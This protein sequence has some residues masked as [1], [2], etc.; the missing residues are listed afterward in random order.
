MRQ[1]DWQNP[2]VLSHGRLPAHTSFIPY[3]DAPAAR[4]DERAFS[5]YYRCLNGR[6]KFCY[7]AHPGAVPE[8][9]EQF[10]YPSA[11]E[12]DDIDVPGCWQM[13]GWGRNQYTN[14]NYPFPLNPP[15]VPDDT[16][17]GVYRR[18]FMVPQ[19]WDGRRI[20]LGFDGVDSCYEVFV[21]GQAVG[22]SKVPHMP[23]EF[24]ITAMVQPG[25]RNVVAVR[26]YQWSDGS[27][28]ED[29]D[30][31]RMS[32][33]FR[34]VYMMGLPNVHIRDIRCNAQLACDGR[35]GV[36]QLEVDVLNASKY[37]CE[38]GLTIGAHLYDDGVDATPIDAAMIDQV[39]ADA[40]FQ[41]TYSCELHVADVAP[42]SAEHPRLYT[43][44]ISLDGPS[45]ERFV[46][47][48]RVGF[49]TVAICGQ[50]F[51][52]NGAPIKIKGVNRHDDHPDLGHT[53]S[54]DAMRNDLALMKQHNINA[55]RTSHYPNDARFLDLCDEYGLYV[56]DETDLESHGT[57]TSD[58]Y[59]N[60]SMMPNM[61]SYREAFVD[62]AERMVCRDRNHA[63]I[64]MWSLGN[65]SGYGPSH[66]AMA[67][68]IRELDVTRPIHYESAFDAAVV[69]VVSV[70]YHSVERLI[71]EGASTVDQRPFFLCEYAHAMGNSP[72]SLGDYWDAIYASPR[73]M[74]GCVWEWADHGIRM[75][76]ERGEWFAYGGDFGEYPHDGSF[77]LD[78]LV[79]PDR[80]P[81]NG[82]IE[83]KKVIQPAAFAA[84]DLATGKLRIT[85][86]LAF[87]NLN[88]YDAYW[89][90]ER[91]GA[92]MQEGVLAPIDI[93]PGCE[94]IVTVPYAMPA[95]G[96]AFVTV[97]LRLRNSA[98][99]ASRGHLLAWEQF[100]LP[101]AAPRVT[102][103]RK[104]ALPAL[105]IS[106]GGGALMLE[107]E[108]VSAAFCTRRGL[109]YDLTA[110]GAS[111]IQE[112]PRVNFWRAPTNNDRYYSAEW[113]KAG[114][115]VADSRL[116]DLRTERLAA[117]AVR[118]GIEQVLAPVSR[119]PILR[120]LLTY[121][122]YG[123]GDI[124]V[125]ASFEPLRETL[126]DLPR[127]GM[128][129]VMPG[130]YD[131]AE[132]FGRG[133]HDNYP[134]RKQSAAMGLYG[135][136]VADM[137]YPHI[138][139]QASGAREDTRWAVITDTM[140][141]GLMVAGDPAFSFTASRYTDRA[142]TAA[143]HRFDL[144]Q[145]DATI[146]SIDLAQ[147]GIGSNSCGPR[148]MDKYLLT[149]AQPRSYAFWLK[150]YQRQTSAPAAFSRVL[151]E[152]L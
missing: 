147:G 99:W 25:S 39:S 29:Q 65:E 87:T 149:L 57:I 20:T 142:L 111:L 104:D 58:S 92:L 126:P 21:N 110:S 90:I 73:L 106:E 37:D 117:G 125:S 48:K 23:A 7:A 11:A 129:L 66:D 55:V 130:R 12:W 150:P 96:E 84:D 18:T 3:A 140:G 24:D 151:P 15:F 85:N 49:R 123:T 135:S 26:V 108:A 67:A 120:A 80:V 127:L 44:I 86:R 148:P 52:V 51:T 115:D 121:T 9:F 47:G 8:G 31:W 14:I 141:L 45:G 30:M 89:R 4:Q 62:R 88:A 132:W 69:D 75:K 114:Y 97:E 95:F 122:V 10:D 138:Q 42:W 76:D 107:G 43:L 33:I 68:R 113:L 91:D 34:D 27:Y 82:L 83:Y 70:M 35:D 46:I 145:S 133:P 19:A 41:K 17:M 124:R 40:G 61:E 2:Q 79:S 64:I 137:D 36:L 71:E 143:G 59:D 131:R 144:P 63:C 119:L 6:W 54:I 103:L 98:P 81:G 94:G 16:P 74:G 101:C 1:P 22:M 116:A 139:P 136:A 78:G 93:A 102:I 100:A 152:V 112:A 5:P 32:G 134:D 60:Y 72:G 13:Q 118:V 146:V 56:I 50:V 53:V 128:Q 38:A 28:L 105:S 77:C 109:L